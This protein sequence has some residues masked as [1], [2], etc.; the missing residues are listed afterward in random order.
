MTK[1][2]DTKSVRSRVEQCLRD[3]DGPLSPT[4]VAQ[5]TGQPA[6][7]V[8]NE[9]SVLARMG[10][11]ETCR[12]NSTK[13][14]FLYRVKSLEGVRCLEMATSAMVKNTRTT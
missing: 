14:G 9:L 12:D 7:R 5:I 10:F 3:A 8:S 2:K 13:N 4:Q 11:A 6:K 1:K